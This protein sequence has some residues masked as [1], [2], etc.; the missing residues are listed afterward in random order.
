[1]VRLFTSRYSVGCHLI[2]YTLLGVL[3]IFRLLG[4]NSPCAFQISLQL[5]HGLFVVYLI[6]EDWGH[7]CI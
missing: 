2:I 7:I 1:M 5:F 3:V 6:N 4:L